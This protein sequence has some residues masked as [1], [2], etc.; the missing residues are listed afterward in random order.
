VD[1]TIDHLDDIIIVTLPGKY[2]DASTV[3]KFKSDVSAVIEG[4]DKQ[5]VFDMCNLQFINSSGLG[6][7]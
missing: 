3:K 1:L 6:A 7:I 5:V 4:N 2:L